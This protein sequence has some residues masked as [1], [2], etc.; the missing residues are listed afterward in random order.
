MMLGIGWDS[1]Y[2]LFDGLGIVLFLGVAYVHRLSLDRWSLFAYLLFLWC[3][4]SA[5]FVSDF[6]I[7]V[8]KVVCLIE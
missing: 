3:L 1:S 2:D 8:Y 6:C 7:N 5:Y 4:F